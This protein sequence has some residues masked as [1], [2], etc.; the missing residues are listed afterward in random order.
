MHIIATNDWNERVIRAHIIWGGHYLGSDLCYNELQF[1]VMAVILSD[2]CRQM[3]VSSRYQQ[4]F[5]RSSVFGCYF[6]T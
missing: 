6:V 4:L 3:Q 1:Q 2:I 5:G